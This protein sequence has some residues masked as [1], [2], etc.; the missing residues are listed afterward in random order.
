[1]F[2]V[3]PRASFWLAL[4]CIILMHPNTNSNAS[5]G[6][7]VPPNSP[8]FIL[9]AC[10]FF[11]MFI[12]G[13]LVLSVYP[14]SVILWIPLKYLCCSYVSF[15]FF[16]L[17]LMPWMSLCF[18]LEIFPSITQWPEW[19]KVEILSCPLSMP[20][21]SLADSFGTLGTHL[22][23]LVLMPFLSEEPSRLRSCSMDIFVPRQVAV[24]M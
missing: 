18:T 20:Y 13:M 22:I 3:S 5:F 16:L 7:S 4:P 9:C 17:W 23:I 2:I 8:Y 1:M 19:A 12:I 21:T 6:A 24:V 11:I 14:L 15:N 10:M